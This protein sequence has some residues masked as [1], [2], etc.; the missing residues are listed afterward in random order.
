MFYLHEQ[1]LPNRIPVIHRDLKSSNILL[2]E[3]ASK[4]EHRLSDIILKLTDF[5]LARELQKTTNEMSAAGTYSHM[6]PEVI[7]S[8]TYSKSSD[9]WSFGV[10]LW[11]LLTGEVPYKGIDPLAIA[12]GVA[13]NKLTLPIPSTC[14]QIFSDLIHACWHTDPHKR[15]SFEQIMECLTE[16]SNSPFATTPYESF[17]T[18]QQDWKTEIQEMFNEIKLR[19]SELRSREEELER[20]S[21]RQ[22]AYESMLRQR[23]KEL[24][25]REKDLAVRELSVALQQLNPNQM[26][27]QQQPPPPEPKK[28]RRVGG[29]LLNTFLRSSSSSNN[30]NNH[31]TSSSNVTTSS[32][33]SSGMGSSI[34]TTAKSIDISSPSDFQHCLSV[35]P[36]IIHQSNSIGYLGENRANSLRPSLSSTPTDETPDQ[37]AAAYMGSNLNQSNNPSSLLLSPVNGSGSPSLRLKI[38]GEF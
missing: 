8:S 4:N 28:R 36:E 9:V 14:P 25:E 18:M 2:S 10:L 6:P 33:N 7:K 21:M 17:W 31:N 35:Q 22:H 38:M 11:E 23:E 32:Y 16:I 24:E 15:L 13:V 34:L 30:N 27:Q 19:E 20:I 26:Q 3:D 37:L 29:R 1:A 12:Y 5:G